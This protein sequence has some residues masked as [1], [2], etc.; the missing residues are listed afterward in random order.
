MV[1][2]SPDPHRLRAAAPCRIR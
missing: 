1:L 2:V